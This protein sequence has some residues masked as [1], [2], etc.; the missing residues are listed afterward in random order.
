[1]YFQKLIC[2]HNIKLVGYFKMERRDFLK[3]FLAMGACACCACNSFE[4][5]E[6]SSNKKSSNYKIG[7]IGIPICYHCNLNCAYCNHYS[8]IA[9]K[10]ELPVEIFTKDIKK[11]HKLTNGSVSEIVLVGGEPLL[12]KDIVKFIKVLANYFPD[13][14]KAIT[15]NG[16]LLKDMNEDFWKACRQYKV[17][18]KCTLYS[19]Y[20]DC[21]TREDIRKLK[22][23]HNVKISASKH[24]K[25]NFNKTNLTQN[26]KKG[27]ENN[28]KNCTMNIKCAQ[29][30]QG[31]LYPCCVMSNIR[32][33]NNHF[34][35]YAIPIKEG[36]YL[37]IHKISSVSE[38]NEYFA[39]DKEFCKYCNYAKEQAPWK[40][41]KGEL[42]EWYDV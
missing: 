2:Y 19:L 17:R 6:A 1:M 24:A 26:P 22:E 12:H 8:P 11:L 38:I 20:K 28:C 42:S 31:L 14:Q 39:K 5:N 25:F 23:K 35:D 15:T 16:L 33:F 4:N 13:T 37:N 36:D 10:Y 9:P 34:K 7:H 41:S 27:S 21:P 30:D 18:I 40:L 32:F 29:L 3:Y